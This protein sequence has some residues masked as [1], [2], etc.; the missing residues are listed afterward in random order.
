M[1]LIG[2]TQAFIRRPFIVKSAVHGLISALLAMCP[3]IGLLYMIEKDFTLQNI[4][5]FLFLGFAIIV[6]GVLINTVSTYFS[7]NRYL[8]ISEDQLYI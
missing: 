7:V 1:Q 8:N 4:N 3:L 2:A 6:L 5:L